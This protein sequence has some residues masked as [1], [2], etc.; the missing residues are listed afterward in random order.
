VTGWPRARAGD[1]RGVGHRLVAVAAVVALLAA[2]VAH[3]S[4]RPTNRACAAAWNR[5][6][7]TSLR[8]AVTAAG[9]RVAF[10]DS[11]VVAGFD[12][13]KGGATTSTQSPG[14]GIEFILR[15]GRTLSVW[16]AWNHDR[17]PSWRGPVTS[18]RPVPVVENAAVGADGTVAF[19]G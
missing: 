17:V 11:A 3:A 5:S 6:A 14:C 16:G 7:S 13:V 19:K 8:H 1:E 4:A 2:A 12:W 10:V 15:G 9:A 18:R